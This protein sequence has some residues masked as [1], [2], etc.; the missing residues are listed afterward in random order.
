MKDSGGT[1][2]YRPS[3]SAIIPNWNRLND[4]RE[5]I[6]AIKAQTYP[7]TEII[8]VDNNSSDGSPQMIKEEFPEV[9]LIRSPHNAFIHSLNIG[10][11]TA[12]GDLI[13]PQDNHGV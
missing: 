12:S 4:L 10:A 9:Q 6:Q 11:K 7:I 2:N 3:V 13:L 5:A 1:D 8:V